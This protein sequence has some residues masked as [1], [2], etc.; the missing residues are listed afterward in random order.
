MRADDAEGV[1]DLV[2]AAGMFPAEE[3]GVVR[4]LLDHLAAGS[5]E[6]HVCLVEEQDEHVVAVAYY[7]PKEPADRVWD[8]TMIAVAPE[9]QGRGLGGA[10]LG[11]V[12]ADLQDRD[13]RLLVVD[14]SGAP[15]YDRTRAFYRKCGYTAVARVPD[16]WADGDDLVV[17]LKRLRPPA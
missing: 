13:Q 16:Y 10:L 3:S 7:Q 9:L 17:F 4:T 11:R 12:E 8:L 1:V 15:L 6:H 5:D 14:T 2:V